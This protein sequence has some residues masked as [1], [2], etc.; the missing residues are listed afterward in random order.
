MLLFRSEEHIDNWCEMWSQPRGGTLTLEQTWQLAQAWYGQDR[1][2]TDW[3]RKTLQEAM[4]IFGEIG[5]AGPFWQ[6]SP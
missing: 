3:R 6:L 1:R 5:M 2:D 4:A